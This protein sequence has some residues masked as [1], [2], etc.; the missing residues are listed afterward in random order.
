MPTVAFNNY[1]ECA[2]SDGVVN[3][4]G[5]ELIKILALEWKIDGDDEELFAQGDEAISIN[6]GNYKKSGTLTVYKGA[7]D[8]MTAAAKA[9][10]GRWVMDILFTIT[11]TYLPA[12]GRPVMVD[13]LG[14]VK[15]SSLTKGWNQGDKM[16][17]IALPFKFITL[18]TTP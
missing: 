11:Q 7:L 1:Q 8:D 15:I 5:A 16:M 3:I 2:W 4:E 10:G 12:P 6:S 18:N 17:K 14:S 13:T 9:A